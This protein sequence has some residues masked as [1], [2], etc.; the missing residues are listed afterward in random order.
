MDFSVSENPC[1]SLC[2][3]HV[4]SV[5]CTVFPKYSNLFITNILCNH[6]EVFLQVRCFSAHIE[7]F[8][9]YRYNFRSLNCH[10]LQNFSV[11]EISA[12]SAGFFPVLVYAANNNGFI[13]DCYNHRYMTNVTFS[14]KRNLHCVLSLTVMV[15]VSM[16]H[17]L[18]ADLIVL[19]LIIAGFAC[20]I[21]G[22]CLQGLKVLPVIIAGFGCNDYGFFL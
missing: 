13:C 8:T 7:L 2:C 4:F 6:R 14:H 17:H 9:C 21:Y 12:M 22:F 18:N 5:L 3:L 20:N 16:V 10:G 19:S 11:L 15:T 1:A